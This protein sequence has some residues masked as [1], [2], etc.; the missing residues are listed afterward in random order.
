MSFASKNFT[1]HL[2][3]LVHVVRATFQFGLNNSI[4][5][6][7]SSLAENLQDGFPLLKSPDLLHYVSEHSRYVYSDHNHFNLKTVLDE[8]L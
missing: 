4:S 3:I 6:L 1:G 2:L 7:L 8:K 5:I